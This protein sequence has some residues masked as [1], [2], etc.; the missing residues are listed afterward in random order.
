MAD[1]FTN[2]VFSNVGSQSACTCWAGRPAIKDSLQKLRRSMQ[3]LP[4]STLDLM[5]A[6]LGAGKTHTLLYFQRCCAIEKPSVIS[7]F[8]EMPEQIGSFLD[9][10]RRLVGA[11][12]LERLAEAVVKAQSSAPDPLYRAANVL[13]NGGTDER[14]IIAEWLL[15]GRPTIRELKQ[16]S[17]ITARIEDDTAATDMMCAICAAFAESQT[18]LLFLVDEYQRVG[19]LRQQARDRV[20]SSLRTVFSRSPS[21][22]SMILSVHSLV[23]QNALEFVPPELKTLIGRRPTISLPAMDSD[24]AEAFVRGRFSCFRPSGFTGGPTDP[25]SPDAVRAVIQFMSGEADAPLSPREL[26]QAF[27]F[28]FGRAENPDRG[29][30]STEA[31]A[32]TAQLYH[33]A[34]A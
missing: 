6:N 15:A 33:G 1:W 17:G 4:E 19:V 16:C 31:L 3:R 2:S 34:E 29:I 5:W 27:G 25:F 22:F 9:L 20:L 26:L 12:P 23:E 28:I 11:L 24:D 21:Y 10:Y 30:D 14:R 32:L 18:R 8:V 7:A 13:L